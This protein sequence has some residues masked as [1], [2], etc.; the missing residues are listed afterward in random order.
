M[1]DLDDP[2]CPFCP[3]SDK[4]AG[5]VAEHINF[6][7]PESST[8]STSGSLHLLENTH[9]AAG[10]FSEEVSTDQYVDCPVGCGETVTAAE[11][12]THLD[13]HVAEDTAMDE[14]GTD[15]TPFDLDPITS[16]YEVRSCQE[17]SLDIPVS[18]RNGKRD[19]DRDFARTNS[20][21]PGRARSPPQTVGPDG[22]RRLGVSFQ[23][24][25]LF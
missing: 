15:S 7:H 20:S 18:R 19:A 25:R 22:A 3:F 2:T 10:S 24:L 11:L 5:F 6:C 23:L 4:D 17:D 9:R 8:T 14:S 13:L 21:K 16:D 12:S 1:A